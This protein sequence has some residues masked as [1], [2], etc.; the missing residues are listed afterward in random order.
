MRNAAVST[1]PHMS[2]GAVATPSAANHGHGSC[3][4]TR[5]QRVRPAKVATAS[6]SSADSA[7]SQVR[8]HGGRAKKCRAFL[9]LGSTPTTRCGSI[10]ACRS[11]RRV[12]S[13]AMMTARSWSAARSASVASSDGP[14][15][16]T[17]TGRPAKAPDS[18]DTLWPRAMAGRLASELAR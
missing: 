15:P 17:T 2:T 7:T 5:N 9:A 6:G 4:A 3:S 12:V 13:V 1:E 18:A 10:P 8:G 14:A 11:G 16:T